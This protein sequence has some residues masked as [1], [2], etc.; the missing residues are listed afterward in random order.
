MAC[1]VAVTHEW[2]I[3][4]LDISQAFLQSGNLRPEGRLIGLAPDMAS[5]PWNGSLPPIGTDLK[6]KPK[7]CYGFL[8]LRPFTGGAM[9]RC[10]GGLRYRRECDV[11]APPHLKSDVCMF[12]KYD[13]RGSLSA[14]VVCRVGDILFTGT[15]VELGNV[16][17]ALRTFRAGKTAHLALGTPIVYTGLL[18]ELFSDGALTLSQTQYDLDPKKISIED[19]ISRGEIVCRRAHRNK[20]RQAMGSLIWLRQTR[21][22]IGFD[23]QTSH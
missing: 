15:D 11:T 23:N 19:H 20:L 6:N 22:D 7:N 10:D 21:P 18:L 17:K 12:T 13:C 5:L 9:P 1:A 16:E 8:L 14:F 4:A 2:K 3:N